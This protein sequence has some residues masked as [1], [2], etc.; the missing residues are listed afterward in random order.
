MYSA[1]TFVCPGFFWLNSAAWF[2]VRKLSRAASADV[3]SAAG[4]AVTE[5]AAAADAAG[6]GV[7]AAGVASIM[8]LPH[9]IVSLV[10]PSLIWNFGFSVA[11]LHRWRCR[12]RSQ[13]LALPRFHF[14][15]RVQ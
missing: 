9:V 13:M 2:A 11:L 4:V 8:V 12:A 14:G 7:G 6:A 5:T 3:V 1:L 10:P 15:D